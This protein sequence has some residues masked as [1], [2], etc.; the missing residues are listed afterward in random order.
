MYRVAY[1]IKGIEL[2]G[3]QGKRRVWNLTSAAINEKTVTLKA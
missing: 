1:M 2:E 3:E